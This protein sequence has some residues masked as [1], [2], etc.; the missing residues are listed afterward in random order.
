MAD[1]LNQ[2][3]AHLDSDMVKSILNGVTLGSVHQAKV[4]DPTMVEGDH[5]M[6]QEVHVTAGCALAQM[7]VTDWVEVQKEDL[8]LSAVLN[9]LKAQKTDLKALLAEHTSSGEGRLILCSQQNFTVHQGAFYLHLMPKGETEDL[10]L[11]LVPKAYWDTAL[12]RCHQD[13]GHQGHNC[14]LGHHSIGPLACRFY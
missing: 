10:L 8:T 13:V 1:A 4:H 2:V 12:N 5:N 9:W 7:H 6:E 14:T 3:T 11:F